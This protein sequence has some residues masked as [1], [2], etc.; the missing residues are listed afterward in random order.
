MGPREGGAPRCLCPP[1]I[2]PLDFQTYTVYTHH[3]TKSLSPF[4]NLLKWNLLV[5]VEHHKM[6]RDLTTGWRYGQ[7]VPY[8]R[9]GGYSCDRRNTR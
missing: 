7:K 3:M 8:P 2:Y 1:Q 5:K 6:N 4:H 9:F